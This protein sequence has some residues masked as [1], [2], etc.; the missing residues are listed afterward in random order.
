MEHRHVGKFI[1]RN[2]E[3]AECVHCKASCSNEEECQLIGKTGIVSKGNK[4]KH[5]WRGVIG[6]RDQSENKDGGFGEEL[7]V[8]EVA[9]ETSNTT[10][11]DKWT[12]GENEPWIGGISYSEQDS[13]DWE[14]E[15]RAE[16]NN[17]KTDMVKEKADN[18]EH[19]HLNDHIGGEGVAVHCSLFT[20]AGCGCIGPIA[21]VAVN[22]FTL[23]DGSESVKTKDDAT[24]EEH[25]DDTEYDGQKLARAQG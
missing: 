10:D 20:A 16:F 8:G 24:K 7:R 21:E 5:R 1:G 19:D 6:A 14:E 13:S 18:E 12:S 9:H 25:F 11:T 22:T 3:A 17:T 15:R 4:C 2:K 23:H